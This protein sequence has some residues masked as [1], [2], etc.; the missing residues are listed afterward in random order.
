MKV[1]HFD[2]NKLYSWDNML[3]TA[4]IALNNLPKLFWAWPSLL[5]RLLGLLPQLIVGDVI[6]FYLNKTG[7]QH[8]PKD[9]I[10]PFKLRVSFDKLFSDQ[11]D[12]HQ[13]CPTQSESLN[14]L[15]GWDKIVPPSREV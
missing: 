5:L 8:F 15:T 1:Y 3:I 4:S 12:F 14:F 10:N 11:S 7:F 6:K 13:N 2:K 9:I